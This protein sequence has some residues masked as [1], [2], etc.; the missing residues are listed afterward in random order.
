M[1][2]VKIQ[3]VNCFFIINKLFFGDF[4]LGSGASI[5][6]VRD[7]YQAKQAA[8]KLKKVNYDAT[9]HRDEVDM[10]NQIRSYP[11]SASISPERKP[12]NSPP[13]LPINPASSVSAIKKSQCEFLMNSSF[14][15]FFLL[16]LSFFTET[17]C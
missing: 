6:D 16:P 14:M 7:L 5:A 17:I 4:I 15:F 8:R 3:K 1:Y 11:M 2:E 9:K 13:K 10:S 12:T